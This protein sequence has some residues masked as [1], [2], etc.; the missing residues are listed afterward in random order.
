MSAS[1]HLL[2]QGFLPFRRSRYPCRGSATIQAVL[3]SVDVK[4]SVPSAPSS[5]WAADGLP[6]SENWTVASHS[7]RSPSLSPCSLSGGRG[8]G[9][10]RDP[11]PPGR[12][13][14]PRRHGSVC[15]VAIDGRRLRR[16]TRSWWLPRTQ[17]SSKIAALLQLLTF[18]FREDIFMY[19]ESN[20]TSS[21][22]SISR[23]GKA[24]G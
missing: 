4:L 23:A 21:P 19:C 14:A 10:L 9:P 24:P 17:A 12:R 6:K 18:T 3:F 13:S 11:T 5:R 7:T 8:H 2:F 22:L 16:R 15:R 20:G 1:F